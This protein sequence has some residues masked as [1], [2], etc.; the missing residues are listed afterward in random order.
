MTGERVY[1]YLAPPDL[2]N[3]RQETGKSVAELFAGEGLGLSKAQNDRVMGWYDLKEW[4]H[5]FEDETGR[6]AANLRVFSSCVNLIR[7]IPALQFDP[8]N[9]N[10]A[11]RE[12]H[13][14]THGPDAIRYFVAGRPRPNPAP[15]KEGR[16]H[17]A[18]ERPGK[19]PAGRGEKVR[20]L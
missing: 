14:I 12:P 20:V 3:R 15:R 16:Y 18:S 2:W 8:K 1:S 17:F 19:D 13:E 4:L 6:A 10:D 7:C 11:A 5:P 9:P